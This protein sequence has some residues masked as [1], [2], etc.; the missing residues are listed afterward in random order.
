M[1][2]QHLNRTNN[3]IL[4]V[5]IITSIFAFAGLMSQLTLAANMKPY[6]SIIPLVLLIATLIGSFIVYAGY[7]ETLTYTGYVGIAFSVVYFFMMIFGATSASFPYMI[8]FLLVIMLALDKKALMVPS[9]VFVVTNII[10]IIQTISGAADIN[11]VIETCCIEFIIT[12]LVF[13]SIYRGLKLLIQ[14]FEESIEEV[15]EASEKNAQVADKI[16]EVATSVSERTD[17]MNNSLENVLTYT[18]SVNNSMDDISTGITATAEAI[19][20]QTLQT[21]EIQDVIDITHERAENVVGIT[22]ETRIALNEGTKAITNLFEQVDAAIQ[23]SGRMQ[24]ASS[25]LQE[26][27]DKV[28]G[29]TSI[30]LGISSQTNLLALNASIEAARAGESGRGFAVVADEIRNLAEQTRHETENISAI[31]E[32]LSNNANVVKERVEAN[33]LSSEKE[34]EYAKLA[35]EKFEDITQKIEVLAQEIREISNRIDIL[36]NSNNQIVDSVNTLSATSEE[37]SASTQE[38][39]VVTEKNAVALSEFSVAMKEILEEITQ[40]RQLAEK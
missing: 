1:R 2:E 28:R 14:F 8:P 26:N 36:R 27:T 24:E 12:I 11:D 31:I 25:L 22:K 17:E 34:N 13:I 7:K 18:N 38:A 3:L 23:D 39:C 37:I 9:A 6:Q 15:T 10:R 32:E 4:I 16:F 33:V 29:I 19:T 40:L 5:H 35:A 21:K 20:N 30:I